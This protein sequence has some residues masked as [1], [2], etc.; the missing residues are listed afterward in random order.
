[1]ISDEV[2]ETDLNKV[3]GKIAGLING[4]GGK[5]SKEDIWGRRKLCYTIKKQ[6]FATYVTIYFS[7]PADKA[8]E[9]ER[10]IRLETT[11]IRQLMMVKDYGDQTITL[12]Q[13]EIA[14]TEEIEAL[15]GH[16]SFEA[17]EG[18]TEQSRDLM[19]VREEKEEATEV[20]SPKS[21]VESPE[22]ETE[23]P[24]VKVE[25]V[26]AEIKPVKKEK[27]VKEKP[28]VEVKEEVKPVRKVAKKKEPADEAERLSKLNEELDDIL[29]DE[30]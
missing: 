5:I 23:E 8:R 12:T 15:I 17:I 27:V 1:M 10:E 19:A 26:E 2:R 22:E 21:K 28:V 4:L 13:D 18:E 3:T 9:L 24:E 7:L 11:V 30:L 16:K 29:K 25:K 14:G 20:E 6:D